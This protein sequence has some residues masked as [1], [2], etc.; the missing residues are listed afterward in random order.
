MIIT[1]YRNHIKRH[2]IKQ[3]V[4][5]LTNLIKRLRTGNIMNIMKVVKKNRRDN[6]GK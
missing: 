1:V 2:K 5:Q 6:Y 4:N 3:Q